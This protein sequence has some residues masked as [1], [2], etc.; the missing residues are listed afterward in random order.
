[1][2]NGTG[3]DYQLVLNP[4]VELRERALVNAIRWM[5]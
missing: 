2:L 4:D 1:M 3:G 5:D